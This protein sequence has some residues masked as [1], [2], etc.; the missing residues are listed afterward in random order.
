M[1]ILDILPLNSENRLKIIRIAKH[2]TYPDSQ[3]S[4]QQTY[5]RILILRKA[6]SRKAE[7]RLWHNHTDPAEVAG[8]SQTHASSHP[9]IVLHQSHITLRYMTFTWLVISNYYKLVGRWAH[10]F[11][12]L[13]PLVGP[14][15]VTGQTEAVMC[16]R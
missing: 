11:P 7:T 4:G 14:N 16:C 2:P 9:K 5:L 15:C 6:R 10:S 1:S 12:V 8:F 3:F 13:A